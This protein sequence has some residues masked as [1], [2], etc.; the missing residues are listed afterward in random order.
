[1]GEPLKIG[2]VGCAEGTHGKV[3]GELLAKPD[4]ARFGMQPTRVWDSS[5]DAAQALASA[6]GATVV[7]HPD[8]AAE[9]V[10]GVMITEL[11]PYRYLELAKP[12]LQKGMR[13]FL[14][15][16]FAGSVDDAHEILR[17]AARHGAKVYSASALYHTKAAIGAREE[18]KRIQPLRLFN[19]TGASDHVGFYLPHAI[20]A[21]AS[22]LGTGVA[23][24]RSLSLATKPDDPQ[25]ATEPVVVYVEYGADS[26]VGSARGTVQMIGPGAS[27]Y[28]FSMSMFGAHGEAAETRF[29]VTYDH[30][31]ET[32]ARFFQTG[33]EPVPREAILE[34]TCVFYAA[35]TSARKAS[36]VVDLG[37]LMRPEGR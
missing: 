11:M 3:W 34:Q 6:T 33:E 25:Q 4:G 21:M 19:V 23:R 5:P 26:S 27:W 13:L 7:R 22:V 2:I 14:N 16:P 17:L 28:G 35:L 12:M 24:I 36:A 32:M 8:M 10:D 9:G 15:R 31:L 1:M 20:A 18:L 37:R 29:E 30:L